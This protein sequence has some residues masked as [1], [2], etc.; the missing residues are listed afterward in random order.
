MQSHNLELEAFKVIDGSNNVREVEGWRIRNVNQL[1]GKGFPYSQYLED[2]EFPRELGIHY[3]GFER[4]PLPGAGRTKYRE[5]PIVH[6]YDYLTGIQ[7]P[8]PYVG[9]R[10]VDGT[11]YLQSLV[12]AWVYIVRAWGVEKFVEDML[13][14]PVLNE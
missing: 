12:N 9:V 13:A 7:I 3:V 8:S 14:S 6:I 1:K 5:E 4:K 11:L 10:R 2:G